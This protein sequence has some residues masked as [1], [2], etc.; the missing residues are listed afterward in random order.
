MSYDGDYNGDGALDLIIGDPLHSTVHVLYGFGQGKKE[1][2]FELSRGYTVY[3]EGVGGSGDYLGWSVSSGGDFNGDGMSDVM[4][5][6]V[7]SN[8]VYIMFGNKT[9]LT[10][11]KLMRKERQSQTIQG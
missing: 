3:G 7:L 4:M 8:K 5:S 9:S 10:P 6:A 1:G 11:S 2:Y